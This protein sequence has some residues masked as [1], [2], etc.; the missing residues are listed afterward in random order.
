MFVQISTCFAV[1]HVEAKTVQ[2]VALTDVHFAD[3]YT[4]GMENF[5]DT[6]PLV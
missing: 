3:L 1:G 2:L 6:C 5:S 4:S